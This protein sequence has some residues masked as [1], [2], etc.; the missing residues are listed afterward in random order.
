MSEYD[1]TI[2]DNMAVVINPKPKEIDNQAKTEVYDSNKDST[3]KY[4]N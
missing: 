4:E 2:F 3:I 1:I